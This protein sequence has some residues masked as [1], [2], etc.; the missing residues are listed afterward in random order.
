MNSYKEYSEIKNLIDQ[1]FILEEG[2]KYEDFIK[3]LV[4]ILKI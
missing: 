1:Y 3:E 2:E 4:M